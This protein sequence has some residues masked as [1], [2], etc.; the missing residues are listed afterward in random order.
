MSGWDWIYK[1]LRCLPSDGGVPACAAQVWGLCWWREKVLPPHGMS[2]PLQVFRDISPT[3]GTTPGP[4]ALAPSLLDHFPR[5]AVTGHRIP[6]WK[7]KHRSIAAEPGSSLLLPATM[8]PS[9]D[10]HKGIWVQQTKTSSHFPFITPWPES[11]VCLSSSQGN[12][13]AGNATSAQNIEAPANPLECKT[14]FSPKTAQLPA[15][16]RYLS[17]PP[18]SAAFPQAA[19]LGDYFHQYYI[20]NPPSTESANL[21]TFPRNPACSQSCS[22][23]GNRPL[24]KLLFCP[25]M[26]LETPPDAGEERSKAAAFAPLRW[27]RSGYFLLD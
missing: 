9:Q 6:P 5:D 10:A 16:L 21:G 18:P 17:P 7:P 3:T 22:P 12:A 14:T 23:S 19:L 2:V 26:A 15:G 20:Q 25:K 1:V 27:P 4:L 11:S 8:S 24:Q 13:A